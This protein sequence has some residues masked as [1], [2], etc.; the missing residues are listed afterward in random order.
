MRN[1]EKETPI[2]LRVCI[3][4]VVSEHGDVPSDNQDFVRVAINRAKRHYN[5]DKRFRE[6]CAHEGGNDFI[7]SFISLWFTSWK[8]SNVSRHWMKKCFS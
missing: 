8:T 5:E 6:G 3:E 4:K 1:I 2:I 7:R